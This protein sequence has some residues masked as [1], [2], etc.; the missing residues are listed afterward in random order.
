M[1]SRYWFNA[2]IFSRNSSFTIALFSCN[3]ESKIAMFSRIR[4]DVLKALQLPL[5]Q[6]HPNAVRIS[7]SSTPP[8][9]DR[10]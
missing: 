10:C 6:P 2:R 7:A 1:F 3:A 5:L 8:V 4:S 9:I